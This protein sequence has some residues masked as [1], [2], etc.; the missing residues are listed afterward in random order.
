MSEPGAGAATEQPPNTKRP[1]I[2]VFT[3]HWLAM[4]GFGLV[5]TAI[6]L[7]ACLLPAQL[8]HGGEN[9]YVGLAIFLVGGLLVVGLV[10]TPLGLHL[11]RR[12]VE[13]NLV[14]IVDA[15]HAWRRL[16]AFLLV[17]SVMNLVI[18][19]QFTMRA[20]HTM[21]SREFCTSCH[22]MTPEGRAFDQGP[23]AGILCVDCHVGN[24]ALGFLKS[25]LQG[26]HQ[27]I[28]VLTDTVKMPIESAIESGKM[29]PSAETCEECHWKEQPA[30]A[31]L[32]LILRYAED[33][34]NTP[35]TTLLTMNV[36]GR[37]MGG[38]HGAH[39]GEGVEIRFVA[40]NPD[41]QDIPLVEY[42][43]SKTGESRT[44]V[45]KGAN[46][47]ALESQ[48][49]LTM[50]C[51]DCHNRPAHAFQMPDRA[52]DKAIMLGRMSAS[53]PFLKNTSMEVLKATYA[54]SAAAANEIPAALTSYYQSAQP[55]VSRTRAADITEAGQVLADIYSRNVFPEYH[56]TW[57]TYPDNRGHQDSPGCF[58]CHD[59]E[60]TTASGE[61][62]DNNCFRCHQ[63]A[64]VDETKPEVLELL[65][66]DKL[67]KKLQKK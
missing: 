63:P 9:P 52:V 40:T 44:Y 20:V 8:R 50:Q 66:V 64:A 43:N 58:R 53:L 54:S 38:I 35:Q 23:H 62:I 37:I 13:R 12:R 34:A 65:G 49:R 27:L 61:K 6:V 11:A 18:A 29:V 48:P 46:A 67:L 10:L 33:E 3:S 16:L 22:V 5:L 4:L 31:S 55:E 56:V 30:K 26:T 60:H 47:A 57:G 24:G 51:F 15:K 17:I 45:K 14:A 32:K 2:A 28:S 1:V 42:R 19:S 21:E 36:G 39:H 7:W 25:K 41:R 59:G